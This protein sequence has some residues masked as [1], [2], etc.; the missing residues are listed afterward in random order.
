MPMLTVGTETSAVVDRLAPRYGFP[1][2]HLLGVLLQSAA[3]EH[4]SVF[5]IH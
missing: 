4:L 2:T 3:A 5:L 1:Y